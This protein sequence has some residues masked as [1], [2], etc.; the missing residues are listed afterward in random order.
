MARTVNDIKKQMTDAFIANS[1][2]RDAY[3]IT[4]V[5]A[6]FDNT[7]S[8]VS[9]ESI[10]FYVVAF[11][12]Y[13]L[14]YLFDVHVN[15]V[16]TIISVQKTPTLRWFVNKVK[17]FRFGI[18]LV[19]DTD[20]YPA[21]KADGTTYTDEEITALQVVK[22]AAG[23][24]DGTGVVYIKVAGA[25]PAKLTDEQEQALVAY[26]KEIKPAG[27]PVVVRNATA[28]VLRLNLTVYYNPM[29]LSSTGASLSAG[30]SPVVESIKSYISN[31]PF[32]GEYR[33][34]ALIDTLQQVPG[35]VIPELQSAQGSFDNE[36]FT[37]ISAK[38]IPYSGYYNFDES[39]SQITYIAYENIS[40]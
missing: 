26:L 15:Q 38:A 30:G 16:N 4:D 22:Y 28:D 24:E 39:N 20:V 1:T 25:G 21:T 19:P 34:A 13:T 11:S 8:K 17:A 23:S 40:D 18:E 9:L 32:N 35:V 36:T 6:T 10:L 3:S 27:V 37:Q 14:E 29:L 7:F 33:N 31:L 12:I 5:N 2:I